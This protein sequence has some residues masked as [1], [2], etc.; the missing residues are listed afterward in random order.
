M[1]TAS[2]GGEG[3]GG[4]EGVRVGQNGGVKLIGC[5]DKFHHI[6]KQNVIGSA[7]IVLLMLLERN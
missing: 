7:H 2:C 6:V 4:V 5:H 1:L 3:G